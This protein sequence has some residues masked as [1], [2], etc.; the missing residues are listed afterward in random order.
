M[1]SSTGPGASHRSRWALLLVLGALGCVAWLAASSG[2]FAADVTTTGHVDEAL[3]EGSLL[4][5]S[6]D[7]AAG[8]G[9]VGTGSDPAGD[10]DAE[11]E[12]PRGAP[13]LVRCL[14]PDGSPLAGARVSCAPTPV[15]DPA[16]GTFLITGNQQ[17]AIADEH[18]EAHFEAVPQD[19]SHVVELASGQTAL[20]TG[21][22]YAIQR[23]TIRSRVSDALVTLANTSGDDARAA[24]TLEI[25]PGDV[26]GVVVSDGEWSGDEAAAEPSGSKPTRD[27]LFKNA[28]EA[29]RSGAR[30]IAGRLGGYTRAV[31]EAPRAVVH[32]PEVTLQQTTGLPIA[33]RP[34]DVGSGVERDDV[35]QAVNVS[36]ADLAKADGV[37]TWSI[38][39]PGGGTA[40][41]TVRTGSAKQAG[42]L[43]S[44]STFRVP[45]ISPAVRELVAEVP[46]WPEADVRVFLPSS[47][48]SDDQ[49]VISGVS[50]GGEQVEGVRAE[51]L[52]GGVFALR[53]IPH[54]PG[55]DLGVAAHVGAAVWST[56]Q[57]RLSHV[58]GE[59]LVGE[60]AVQTSPVELGA[61]WLL[62][63]STNWTTG[64]GSNGR[65]V[66][67]SIPF[68]R[69]LT[70]TE[71][72]E[73]TVAEGPEEPPPPASVTV[74]VNPAPGHGLRDAIVFL[75]DRMQ[76]L[77]GRGAAHFDD[78]QP[79]TT[80]IRVDGAGPTVSVEVKDIAPGERRDVT[81][82][83]PPP[84]T[85]DV[86][87]VDE[88]GREVPFAELSVEQASGL[89]WLDV[90]GSRQR[91]DPYVDTRGRRT[92]RGLYPGKVVVTA[93]AGGDLVGRGEIES[94]EGGRERLRIVVAKEQAKK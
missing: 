65:L 11:A 72:V 51:S 66:L 53:G 48:E 14:A 16:Q 44:Q 85:L 54:R 78:I 4:G 81:V 24:V 37:P 29:Y 42:L 82:D 20:S 36:Y 49:L 84:L 87:V 1:A 5:T 79:G 45:M 67:H 89:P 13:L 18:G 43:A 3:L 68:I 58:V 33:I 70:M 32:G 93:R 12:P 88:L 59:R 35:L 21:S 30:R 56:S 61:A 71:P 92:L 55:A 76:R 57:L 64:P 38:L 41:V 10:E 69:N 46:V 86:T 39:Q 2:F 15:G 94:P 62:Q 60:L 7:A 83:I 27:T 28:R 80:R 26:T 34:I 6:P 52:G 40:E 77:D 73:V 75:G 63:H 19:G 22:Y 9:L 91:I 31:G 90:E 17:M 23:V 50:L 47:V 25:A 74:T 8:P